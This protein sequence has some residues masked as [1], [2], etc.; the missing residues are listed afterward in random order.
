[1]TFILHANSTDAASYIGPTPF[2][3]AVLGKR[4]STAKL[5]IGIAAAQYQKEDDQDKDK[6]KAA[7]FDLG[8]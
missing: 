8:V 2:H 5:I 3:V 7:L 6:L 4:W 1:M